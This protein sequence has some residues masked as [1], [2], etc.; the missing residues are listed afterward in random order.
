MKNKYYY[1][2]TTAIKNSS[3]L[4]IACMTYGMIMSIGIGTGSLKDIINN[5][6]MFYFM[7][8]SIASMSVFTFSSI[9]FMTDIALSLGSTRKDI[10]RGAN[11]F[12]SLLI[13]FLTII[14]IVLALLSEKNIVESI[15]GILT[16][17][18]SLTISAGIGS[19]A[20][21]LNM[22][23]GA[24]V[25]ISYSISTICSIIIPLVLLFFSGTFKIMTDN[26]I[27]TDFGKK[28]LITTIIAVVLGMITY[29]LGALKMKSQFAKHEVRI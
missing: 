6:I 14:L 11:I 19:F 22:K 5:N 3:A 21:T 23:K 27:P 15:R 13:V 10:F 20:G 24:K 29:A 1:W 12:N 28:E 8:I 16:Y 2:T 25:G 4:V 26:K 9:P 17:V 18:A 7:M